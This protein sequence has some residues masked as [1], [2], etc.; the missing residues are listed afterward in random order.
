MARCQATTKSG[1]RCKRNAPEG[2]DH[3]SVHNKARA[4]SA[5]PAPD[6]SEQRA[7]EQ[8]TTDDGDSSREGTSKKGFRNKHINSS[9]DLL[10]L[11][12]GAAATLAMLWLLKRG[13]RLP[14]V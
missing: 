8:K 12:I 2:E 7:P 1:A 14:G 13:P 9:Q 11:A 6:P 3:C 10:H 5:E 4:Q